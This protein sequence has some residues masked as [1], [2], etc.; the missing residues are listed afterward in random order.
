M[1]GRVN[2]QRRTMTE[3]TRKK[4]RRRKGIKNNRGT[5]V[6]EQKKKGTKRKAGSCD[7]L[8]LGSTKRMKG[9]HGKEILIKLIY[10]LKSSSHY[11]S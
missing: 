9:T 8:I 10:Y 1:K 6:K 5:I 3:R 7:D 4:G 11:V 2:A